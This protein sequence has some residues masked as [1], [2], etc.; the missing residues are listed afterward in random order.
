MVVVVVDEG[1]GL[2]SN[3]RLMDD[4]AS[5]STS[6]RDFLGARPRPI[7]RVCQRAVHG[8]QLVI[9]YQET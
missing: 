1:G 5:C 7:L 4:A 6:L 9:K 3:N 8:T 2:P